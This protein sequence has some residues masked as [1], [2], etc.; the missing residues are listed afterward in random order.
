M[1]WMFQLHTNYRVQLATVTINIHVVSATLLLTKSI[2]KKAM[3][4]QVVKHLFI[5]FIWTYLAW[6]FR[7]CS[8]GRLYTAWECGTIPVHNHKQSSDKNSW[9]D[10]GVLFLSQWGTRMASC[11]WSHSW[12]HAQLLWWDDLIHSKAVW[13]I[14]ILYQGIVND[15]F[16]KILVGGYLLNKDKWREFEAIINTMI[17]PSETSHLP[18]NMCLLYYFP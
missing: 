18:T 10:R 14:N 12:L 3:M 6:N 15:F 11:E 13:L 5:D 7:F 1:L 2:P 8:E 16:K 9:W 17:W 4:P